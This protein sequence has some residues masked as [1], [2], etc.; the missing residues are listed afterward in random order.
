MTKE[1]YI[2]LTINRAATRANILEKHTTLKLYAKRR[3]IATSTLIRILLDSK[4]AYPHQEA[5][6]STYQRVLRKI[7]TNGL[8]VESTE[9]QPLDE[10]A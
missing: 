4:S 5:R 9:A 1:E 8:L 3:K 6:N 2:P 10:A 7:K